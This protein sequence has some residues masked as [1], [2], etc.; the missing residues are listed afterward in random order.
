MPASPAGAV[1]V[2]LV[3]AAA[4][5]SMT[6]LIWTVQVLNYPLLALGNASEVP[7]QEQAH[8]RRWT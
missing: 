7:G 8:N 5:W 4:S 2:L 3:Q 6:G 1:V